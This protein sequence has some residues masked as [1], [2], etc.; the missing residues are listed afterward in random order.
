M[1][2]A[3][4][5]WPLRYGFENVEARA[6]DGTRLRLVVGGPKGATRVVFL[7]G[8]PQF[9]FAWHKVLP[10]LATS[11]RV[12]A[13]DSRGYGA[14]EL[15]ASGR[16][17]LDTLASDVGVVIEQEARSSHDA[18][19]VVAH[20]WGGP[21]AWRLAEQRP[22][23][24][25]HL[26]AI[27][28]PHLAAF[29][30]ELRRPSQ[31]A[32]SWYIAVFDIPGIERA[33][34]AMDAAPFT[35]MLERS[36]SPGAFTDD[37]IALYRACFARPCR[38]GAVLAYYRE[39]SAAVFARGREI[40][41]SRRV[42]VPATVLWGEEDLGLAPTHPDAIRRYAS[43]VEIRR[44][45]GRSHWVPQEAPLEIERAVREGDAVS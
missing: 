13:L 42:G 30:R 38:P 6:Q 23:L 31:L 22:E 29:V 18:A 21:P 26:V 44:L 11:Y 17:D 39:A 9:S 12:I 25:R 5:D 7:H 41:A 34:E 27:N 32:R 1:T 33:I 10:L 35:W 43:R 37:E 3:I 8:A 14:S 24:V 36:S 28:A 20:D 19:I 4:V 45:E 16:Y 40:L 2:R 15:A